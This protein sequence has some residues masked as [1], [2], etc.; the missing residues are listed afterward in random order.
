MYCLL[1]NLNWLALYLCVCRDA[2]DILLN[3]AT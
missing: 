1:K 2:E 3:S